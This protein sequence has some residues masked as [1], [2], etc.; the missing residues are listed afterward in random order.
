LAS[1][2]L[3]SSCSYGYGIRAEGHEGSLVFVIEGGPSFWGPKPEVCEFHV[4]DEAAQKPK[5]YSWS[6]DDPAI[7]WEFRVPS[8]ETGNGCSAFPVTYGKVPAGAEELVK[9]KPLARNRTY[10]VNAYAPGIRGFGSFQLVTTV[11]NVKE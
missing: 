8:P 1:F 10:H 4:T 7:L 9:A 6:K 5:P 2:L 11:Q 3:I